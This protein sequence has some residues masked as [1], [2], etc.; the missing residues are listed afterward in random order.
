M[1]ET[2]TMTSMLGCTSTD[3]R[4]DVL[5]RVLVLHLRDVICAS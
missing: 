3:V 5:Y 2:R 4:E 1:Q